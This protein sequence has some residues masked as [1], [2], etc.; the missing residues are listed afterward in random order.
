MGPPAGIPPP[1]FPA[2]G[3]GGSVAGLPLPPRPAAAGRGR[4]RWPH[5]PNLPAG[6][7]S[8]PRASSPASLSTSPLAAA[9][10]VRCRWPPSPDLPA[11]SRSSRRG[12]HVRGWNQGIGIGRRRRRAGVCGPAAAASAREWVDDVRGRLEGQPL[13]LEDDVHL[14]R[15]RHHPVRRSRILDPLSVFAVVVRPAATEPCHTVN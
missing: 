1:L 2:A 10:R 15:G 8:R 13:G 3:G 9:A 14:R 11:S 5:F 4:R 6:S 12:S 7:S